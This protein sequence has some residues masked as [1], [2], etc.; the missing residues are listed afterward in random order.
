[1]KPPPEEVLLTHDAH[2]GT[3]QQQYP[4]NVEMA[5]VTIVPGTY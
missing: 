1:M 3:E 4:I 2:R 5:L